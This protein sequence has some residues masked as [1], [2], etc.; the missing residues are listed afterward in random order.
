M[1]G[2]AHQCHRSLGFWSHRAHER[3]WERTVYSVP[4]GNAYHP[5]PK[6]PMVR[7]FANAA[8]AR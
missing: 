7:P 8:M 2:A 4:P 6:A 1:S 5:Q 3:C